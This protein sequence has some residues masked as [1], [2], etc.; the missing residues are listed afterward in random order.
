[1]NEADQ[2][3]PFRRRFETIRAAEQRQPIDHRGS[4]VGQS[5]ERGADTRA[6]DRIGIGEAAGELDD[7]DLAPASP[8]A[9]DDAAIEEIAAGELIKAAGNEKGQGRQAS[10]PSKAAQAIGDSRSTTRSVAI[11]PAV[12]GPS[13]PP[14]TRA[15]SR[16]KIS[17]AR[18]SVSRL[19]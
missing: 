4:I 18:N 11:A 5:G 15:A 16:R 14:R 10:P 3:Q 2:P 9:L 13:A 19:R 17:P 6:R 7:L 1:M 8:Q 12:S